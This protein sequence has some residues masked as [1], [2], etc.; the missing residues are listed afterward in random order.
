MSSNLTIPVLVVRLLCFLCITDMYL[1]TQ[2]GAGPVGLVL[3]L[4]LLKNG[5]PVRIIEK[6]QTPRIG[7]RGAG[8]MVGLVPSDSGCY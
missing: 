5:V 2:V 6:E 8:V 7:Q 1:S 3:A 4:T